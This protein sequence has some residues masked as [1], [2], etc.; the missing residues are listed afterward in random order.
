MTLRSA[1]DHLKKDSEQIGKKTIIYE[2]FS[3]YLNFE[4]NSKEKIFRVKSS[5][6]VICER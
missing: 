4:P 1:L 6:V 2:L 3:M 5:S